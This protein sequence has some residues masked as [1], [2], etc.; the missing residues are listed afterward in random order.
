MVRRAPAHLPPVVKSTL[1]ARQGPPATVSLVR[2]DSLVLV[3]GRSV[4]VRHLRPDDR[5]MYRAAVAGLSARSRYLRF[6]A[7]LPRL[8]EGPDDGVRRHPSRRIRRA[9]ARRDQHRRRRAVRQNARSPRVG[10]S[11]N[12]GRRRLAGRRARLRSAREAHRA[13][14]TDRTAPLDRDHA[15]RGSRSPEPAASTPSTSSR[16]WS[17]RAEKSFTRRH[18]SHARAAGVPV[19]MPWPL[20]LRASGRADDPTRRARVAR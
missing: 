19:R 5:D 14:S 3:D 12:C 2:H 7:P 13:G 9:H 8:S 1:S 15:Q 10:R 4:L 16:S 6:A 11:R 20:L 17:W 18:P